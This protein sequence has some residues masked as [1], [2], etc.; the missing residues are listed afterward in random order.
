MKSNY[1]IRP[2]IEMVEL[3][4]MKQ[5]SHES[6]ITVFYVSSAF[7]KRQGDVSIL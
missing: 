3:L 6:L 2:L 7:G 1:G 5:K 4:I